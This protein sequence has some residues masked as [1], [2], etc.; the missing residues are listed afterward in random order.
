MGNNHGRI[1]DQSTR[2]SMQLESSITIGR[3]P[4]ST[5]PTLDELNEESTPDA[6]QEPTAATVDLSVAPTSP[7]GT[8]ASAGG[9]KARPRRQSAVL[10]DHRKMSVEEIAL[11]DAAS[12]ASAPEE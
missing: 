12:L 5:R 6:S 2:T 11:P 1:A 10:R 7:R 3:A 9:W 8:I 4:S